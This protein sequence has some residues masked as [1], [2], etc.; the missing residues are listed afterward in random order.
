MEAAD[1]GGLSVEQKARI[2]QKFKAAKA[3]LSR[4]RRRD[5]LACDPQINVDGNLSDPS[6]ILV[7]KSLPSHG[8][9]FNQTNGECRSSFI[10]ADRSKS[11]N[12]G[13]SSKAILDLK[14]LNTAMRQPVSSTSKDPLLP[15]TILDNDLDDSILEEIDVLCVQWSAVK[16]ERGDTNNHVKSHLNDGSGEEN[17]SQKNLESNL[18]TGGRYDALNS[19]S[20]VESIAVNISLET[21]DGPDP[22]NSKSDVESI[23]VKSSLEAEVNDLVSTRAAS[24]ISVATQSQGMPVA[25]AKFLQSLNDKQYEAACTDIL[26]PLMIVAGPGSGKTS[27]MVGRVLMLL[28]E[29]IGPSQI[30]AMTFTTAA[31]SEMRD[32]IGAVAG[33][34]IAKELMISTFHSF[35]LQL[36]R[37]YAEKVDRTSDFLIYGH[38]QQKRAVIEAVRLLENE[39]G[40]QSSEAYNSV[41]SVNSP[42]YF[43]DKSK[44][45]QKFVSQAK[46]SGKNPSDC[47]KMGDKTGAAIL[48]NYDDILKSC[49]ALDYHDLISCSVKLLTD[50]PEVFGECQESWKAILIDEFQDTSSMQYGLLKILASHKRITIVGD[51]DQSIFSFNGADISGFDSF[52]KDFPNHKEIRLNK[53][54]R[55][56]RCIV[57]AASYL[58]QNN[59]KRCQLKNVLTDNSS[60]AKIT[61]KDC[62]NEDAQCAFV[63]DKI[64]E[65]TSNCPAAGSSFGEIAILYRRR[66]GKCFKQPS[67]KERYRSTFM[68]WPSIEKRLLD[69]LLLFSKQ[70]FLVV[71]MVHFAWHSKLYCPVIRKKRR[72]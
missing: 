8:N 16:K 53:N 20:D 37:L 40:G 10:S 33:K 64:L 23:S 7:N 54:Y 4:K 65:A 1:G 13:L 58:I 46:A 31:A 61:V 25:Y 6:E 41:N 36:C 14:S 34:A 35:S 18:E 3:L 38:G 12:N 5:T 48:K 32:R 51:D 49:N 68:A 26:I 19:N 17:S 57:E 62:H 15:Q 60:G 39:K 63:V 27:T 21:E 50:F 29:G 47:C 30:L 70:H 24:R 43:R 59:N 72:G 45:W 42:Q 11:M 71:T 44:R 66:Q 2:S 52:R 69:L 56:T 55:S 9:S 67:V 22:L 28:N